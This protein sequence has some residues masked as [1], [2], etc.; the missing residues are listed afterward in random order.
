MQTTEV[1]II[2][3]GPFGLSISAHLRSSGVDHLTLGTPMDSWRIYSPSGMFLKSEP[4]G[5]DFAS[6]VGGYD[7][8]AFCELQGL[9]YV[10]RLGP[11][12]L[13]RFLD[14][15]DWYTANLVPDVRDDLVT[16]VTSAD[17]GF[18]VT[19]A[20]GDPVLAR[21]VVIATGVRPYAHIPDELTALPSGLVT[22]T[23]DHHRLEDFSGRRVAVVGAGQ[24]AL[25]TAA[26]LHEAGA[27]VRIIA[28]R[29]ALAW[30][31]A[32]PEQ[33]SPLGRVRRPVNKL[34]EG[35]RCTFWNTPGAFSLLPMEMKATKARTVLGP[36]G[37]WW[38][39]DR[40]DG[41]VDTLTGYRVQKADP[42]GSGLRL[43]LE[44]PKEAVI[45]VE[46]VV[47]GTGFRIDLA[48]LA[49][50]SA[51]IRSKVSTNHGYP[52]VSRVGESTVAGLYFAGAPTAAS[53]GPSVRFIAGTHNVTRLLA[54][55][56]T[57]HARA[58]NRRSLPPSEQA[59][60][61]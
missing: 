14:Y 24:S 17:G 55:S 28:R 40:V 37:A 19:L 41:V 27:D 29:S 7:V 53:L 33:L 57:R 2:G 48:R 25:E 45:D 58:G 5:S 10:H 22:H 6:P 30:N 56:L 1:L 32:N 50:L 3:A 4:Y 26:L 42:R 31:V 35:W 21:R 44:G 54:N 51:E 16:G 9:D 34:C 20:G 43:F 61:A 46:H 15:A 49:F 52:L 23:T 38:L 11:L 59:H 13:E 47:A 18:L 8:S 36:A 39:H 60:V 12:S